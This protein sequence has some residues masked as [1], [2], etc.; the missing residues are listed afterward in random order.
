MKRHGCSRPVALAL[1]DGLIGK[2]TSFFDYGCGW[3]ADVRY[4][5]ARRIRAAG[6]DPHHNPKAR[7]TPA[8]VVNLGY[9]LNVIEHQSERADT[10]RQ[11]YSL[12]RRLLLV[13]VRVDRTIDKASEYGDGVLTG[14]GTFQKI[15]TQQEF[16]TYLEGVLDRRVHVVA[17]GI[18][19]VFKD[20]ELENS[21]LA[22]RAFTRRLEYRTDLID[23]FSRS[24][25]GRRYVR[26]ADRLGRL[27][28]PAEFPGYEQL[29]ERFGSPQRIERLTLRQVRRDVFDG[30]RAHRR[31]DILTYLAMLRLDGMRAPAMHA[32]PPGVRGDIKAIWGSYSS[33]QKEGD[34]FL[35]S[36][37]NPDAIRAACGASPAGKLLPSDLYAHRSLED[38]LPS[39]LRVLLFAAHRI[40]GQL[41][42][43]LVKIATDGRTV[44]FLSYPNFDEDPHPGLTRSVRVYLPKAD[45]LVRDYNGE[46]AP[47]LHRKDA[48]VA[49]SYP[50]YPVFRTLT[51]Q[52]ERHQLLSAPDIGY[53][54]AWQNLLAERGLAIRGHVVRRVED[55]S[56]DD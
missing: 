4:L 14:A 6:W 54:V 25:L 22:S 8:D 19:Y 51:E 35:F 52:E 49:P 12:T 9:V 3:G 32:L 53:R 5:R 37:G 50:F 33:A 28:L 13:S 24:A 45:Y 11:A 43:D 30:S 39:L 38:E 29:V 46:N 42:Y 7:V 16:R 10:L 41:D 44:S 34:T 40:V 17:L 21:F 56:A 36:L 26:L 15:F 27:P 1:A 23:D 18:A 2:T 20:E 31:E 48:L 47:I 55:P